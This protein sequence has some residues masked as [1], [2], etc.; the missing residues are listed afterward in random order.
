MNLKAKKIKQWKKLTAFLLIMF[1]M[2][3][4]VSPMGD[5]FAAVNYVDSGTYTLH[6]NSTSGAANVQT[7]YFNPTNCAD[8][9]INA[10]LKA[11]TGTI[12]FKS[13]S[14]G[15]ETTLPSGHYWFHTIGTDTKGLFSLFMIDTYKASNGDTVTI[16]GTFTL[17]DTA[18][19]VNFEK[20]T[21]KFVETGSTRNWTI[22]PNFVDSGSYSLMSNSNSGAAN[23]QYIYFY[24]ANGASLNNQNY[25]TMVAMRCY[26][27]G[28]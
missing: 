24:P 5:A 21:F 15:Q 20:V 27:D 23:P 10:D 22:M 19:G 9:N 7:I 14:T 3:Q 6:A 12:K 4:I 11:D 25:Q 1:M 17:G 28:H 26:L 16:E 2:V 18:T 8:V 13:A